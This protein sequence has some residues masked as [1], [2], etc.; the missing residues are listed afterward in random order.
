MSFVIRSVLVALLGVCV[1]SGC[2]G[3]ATDGNAVDPSADNTNGATPADSQAITQAATEFMDA[4]L[5]GDSQ[6]A[7]ARL[8]PQAIDKIIAGEVKFNPTG[9]PTA[10][11]RTPTE[12]QAI[13]QFHLTDRS[14]DG[15]TVKEEGCCVLRKVENDW[16]VS[17]IAYGS[18]PNQPWRLDDFEA[19]TTI[20]I[21]K[22]TARTSSSGQVPAQSASRP[23]PPRTAE[24][25][26]TT[27]R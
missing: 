23:S 18:E 10:T 2:G 16:R 7:S 11:I 5:K 13:V 12:G 24:Q 21:P 6:R 1:L 22:Q 20:P 9:L 3:D 19:G 27:I 4:V 15:N 26:P 25:A 14:A 17:G 8:T